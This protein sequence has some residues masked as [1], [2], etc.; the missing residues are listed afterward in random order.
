MIPKTM[1]RFSVFIGTWNTTGDVFPVA[2]VSSSDLV[3]TDT[4]LWVPGQHF[5][6]HQVDARFGGTVSRSIE[7]MGYD[8]KGKKHVSRS[9]SDQG[10]S[11]DFILE[12]QGRQWSITGATV[13]FNGSFDASR[14]TLSGLWELKPPKS[15][16]QR[17]ID[18][19][20][21]RA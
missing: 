13:R 1:S 3:A 9:Y 19:R 5:I 11:E 20:L 7:I 15:R 2:D 17:W 4:Y 6:L 8:A 18:L 12:L 14:N 10:M 21:E 16:W